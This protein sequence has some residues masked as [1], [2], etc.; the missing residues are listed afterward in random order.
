MGSIFI[1]Q[2]I[3]VIVYDSRLFTWRM[4]VARVHGGHPKGT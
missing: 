3:V 2:G 4:G 1:G